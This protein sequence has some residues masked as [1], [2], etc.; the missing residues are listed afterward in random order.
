MY[1]QHHIKYI[2]TTHPS[3]IQNT[4]DFLRAI[5][6]MNMGP[7]LEKNVML[8]TMYATALYDNIPHKEGIECLREALDERENPKIPTGYIQRMREVVM[9]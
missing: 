2:S 5:Q 9:E 7:Q 4:L 8:V 1:V 6:E 3:Y